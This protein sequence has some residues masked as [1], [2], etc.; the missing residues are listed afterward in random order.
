VKTIK[1]AVA[2]IAFAAFSFSAF[3]AHAAMLLQADGMLPAVS[4]TTRD[5]L[6]NKAARSS[7][8]GCRITFTI[9]NNKREDTA[10]VYK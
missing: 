8:T 5:G 10:V 2:A 3:A 4:M 9:D 6:A 1:Y 7:T